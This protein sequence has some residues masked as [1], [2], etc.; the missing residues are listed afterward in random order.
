[1]QRFLQLVDSLNG[2]LYSN[3]VLFTV[4][5]AGALFTVWTAFVQY[6]ALTHGVAL[7]LGRYD[8]SK[9]K[10]ALNH[11]QALSAALSATVGLGNIGGVALAVAIGGPGAVFWMWI[12]GFFG[13]AMKSI[14]VTLSLLYR[15]AGDNGEP[16]GGPM[17]VAR[18]AM[19]E[20]SP[21]LAGV[22]KFV[23][24]VF[25][26][27]LV[28]GAFT[29]GNM[30]QAWNVADITHSYFGVP[31]LL[32]G[33]ILAVVVGLVIVGGIK[34][35]GRIAS[36]LVPFMCGTYILAGLYVILLN[37]DQLPDIF[38][39]I[40]TS[41]FSPAEAQ[42]AFIGGSTGYA[43]LWGMKR[44]IYSNEAG[45]GS[46]P[47]AHSAVKTTEPVTEGIVAGLEPFIDTLVVCTITALVILSTGLWKYGPEANWPVTPEV[48]KAADGGW[49]LP[50]SPLPARGTD[51]WKAGE[52]V[53]VRL[54]G[55]PNPRTGGDFHRLDG[56]VIERDGAL[57]TVWKSTPGEGQLSLADDGIYASYTGAT[58]TARAFDD[59][60]AGLGMWMVTLAVW[61][62]AISTMISWGYYG[63]QG[64][65]YLFGEKLVLPYRLLYC[66]AAAITCLGFIAT[67][68]ELDNISTFGF[69]LMLVINVPLTLLFSYKAIGAYRIYIGKLK[70]GELGRR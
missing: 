18:K 29:G 59:A 43:F 70:R 19:A 64:V 47:I 17:W 2:Y 26:I 8:H 21:R 15:N 30:F 39:L 24:V 45:F 4:L 46:A 10:G 11:F 16:H 12:V 27:A 65:V 5:G 9:G 58:L 63:E 51:S 28:I 68:I 61:L 25:C 67:P 36:L 23:G 7:I 53:F 37:V 55:A 42:G 57:F 56:T 35:I 13:M 1:V 22:G 38:R 31:Q 50:E 60:Q 20:L 54:Q 69:G 48:V 49:T 44:A 41:A 32:S 62:F 52:N 34:R 3:P 6:R 66:A 14:E 33:V 40:F